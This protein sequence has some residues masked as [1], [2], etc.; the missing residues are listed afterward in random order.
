MAT[1]ARSDATGPRDPSC[2][3]RLE[4]GTLPPCGAQR[5]AYMTLLR[6]RIA[7]HRVRPAQRRATLSRDAR[8]NADRSISRLRIDPEPPDQR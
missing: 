6:H 5:N 7:P 1:R 4:H 3:V 2:R 8:S